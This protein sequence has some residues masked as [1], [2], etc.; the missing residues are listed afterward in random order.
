LLGKSGLDQ[1]HYRIGLGHH[2]IGTI[3]MHGQS[4]Q[5]DHALILLHTQRAARIDDHGV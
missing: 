2:I 5:E 1:Q 4:R 3:V